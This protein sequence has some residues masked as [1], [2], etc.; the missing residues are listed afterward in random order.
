MAYGQFWMIVNIDDAV[1]AWGGEKIPEKQAPRFMHPTKELAEQELLRLG[2]KY[3]DTD[4][5]LLESVARV[6]RV[7]NVVCSVEPIDEIPF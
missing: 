4:F 1:D 7:T 5:V 3:P 2:A 6:R